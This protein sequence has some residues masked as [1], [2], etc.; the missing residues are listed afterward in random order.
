MIF[1][2]DFPSTFW[3]TGI[4]DGLFTILYVFFAFKGGLRMKELF[5]PAKS[6]N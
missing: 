2:K 3:F 4:I 6:T 5:I 1:V